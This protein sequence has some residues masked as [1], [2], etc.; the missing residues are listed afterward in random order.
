MMANKVQS[1]SEVPCGNTI[2]LVGI[3]K[4]LIKSGTIS[5]FDEAYSIRPMKYSVSAVVKVAVSPKFPAELPK[6]IE[7][8]KN[9]ARADGLIQCYTEETGEH[10]IAGGGE[11]HL[12]V[13]LKELEKVHA[14][15]EIIISEPVVTYKETVTELSSQVCLAKSQ[16]RH[17]RIYATAEPLSE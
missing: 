13:C 8:M 16:N 7:G 6:L 3:D 9:L 10:I 1:V 5:D 15:I 2:A 12:E 17:N 11:L 4:Y 14:Q